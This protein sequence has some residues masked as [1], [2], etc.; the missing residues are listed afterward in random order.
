MQPSHTRLICR[1]HNRYTPSIALWQ[2]FVL[3][4]SPTPPRQRLLS[5]AT[6]A[7]Q[8]GAGTDTN[9][10]PAKQTPIEPGGANGFQQAKNGRGDAAGRP[11]GEPAENSSEEPATE[12][13][14]DPERKLGVRKMTTAKGQ[15]QVKRAET[16]V[17]K[18]KHAQNGSREASLTEPEKLLAKVREAFNQSRDYEGIVVMP[19]VPTTPIKESSLPWCVHR[20][21]PILGMDRYFQSVPLGWN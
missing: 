20:E 12:S 7:A 4:S 2:H 15:F 16:S 14:T 17:L 1:A 18:N 6:D 3:S 5:T 13:S 8:A 9:N 21:R 11:S 10:P 19:M